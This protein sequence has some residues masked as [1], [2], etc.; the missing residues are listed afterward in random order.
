[1]KHGFYVRIKTIT[2]WQGRQTAQQAIDY[3]TDDHDSKRL[4]NINDEMI[5]YICRLDP[6]YKTEHEGGKVP[7]IGHGSVKHLTDFKELNWEFNQST[8]PADVRGT[9]GYK[10]ITLTLPKEMTLLCET[11]KRKAREAITRAIEP[12]LLESYPGQKVVAVSAMHTRNEAGDPH[13]NVHL[14]IGK[15]VLNEA[16]GKLYSINNNDIYGDLG[17]KEEAR[18]KRAWK[19]EITKELEIEFNVKI[20]ISKKGKCRIYTPDGLEL[21]SLK[22]PTSSEKKR[23]YE[24]AKGPEIDSWNGLADNFKINLMD[25][26]ILEVARKAP[27]TKENFLAV[28]PSFEKHYVIDKRIETLKQHRYLDEDL[29]PTEAFIR[30]AEAKFGHR[31]D[32]KQIKEDVDNIL[33]KLIEKTKDENP[34]VLEELVAKIFANPLQVAIETNEKIAERIERLDP[35]P[36][37]LQTIE[38]HW[39]DTRKQI[40]PEL[41]K[42]TETEHEHAQHLKDTREKSENLPP[43]TKKRYLEDRN[44]VATRLHQRAKKEKESAAA[45][46][47]NPI[48]KEH[49]TLLSTL[50]EDREL[51]QA[52]Q[53]KIE[54]LSERRDKE[55]DFAAE[56]E[57]PYI[58]KHYQ[59]Q[60]AEL[61]RTSAKL[62]SEITRKT[63]RA[64]GM[65]RKIPEKFKTYAKTENQPRNI[66]LPPE[67]A[68]KLHD[69][70]YRSKTSL[71]EY[72]SAR[73]PQ[74]SKECIWLRRGFKVMEIL[75]H[76]DV[77]MLKPIMMVGME[78]KLLQGYVQRNLPNYMALPT[79][80]AREMGKILFEAEHFFMFSR[81][82]LPKLLSGT[83]VE[84]RVNLMIA[85]LRVLGI[86][87]P[88]LSKINSSDF[89]AICDSD[90]RLWRLTSPG[91]AYMMDWQYQNNEKYE[92]ALKRFPSPQL[93]SPSPEKAQEMSYS[94][95]KDKD[96]DKD[97]DQKKEYIPPR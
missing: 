90:E 18:M 81:P 25:A 55:L 77:N 96:K 26:K 64:L 63:A 46:L 92:I 53:A 31:P 50:V 19:R 84:P 95:T 94:N 2:E 27:L 52:I 12:T 3:I 80:K 57:Y 74:L 39:V 49:N 17:S 44:L 28:F 16:T 68:Q 24:I 23:A 11:N 5:A 59:V 91:S 70:I 79:A 32:F 87:Y 83:S 42:W 69:Q 51:H 15:T 54:K 58:I 7:L 4:G 20:K 75:G 76:S 45:S 61:T 8:I 48:L 89:I 38:A 71:K 97:K 10:T 67:A 37:A 56:W 36:T 34:G 65:E 1:M 73:S 88:D 66:Y 47:K 85:R 62:R 33:G 41:A 29:K 60:I 6:G 21:P 22:L 40:T 13:V 86:Q 93:E 14:L 35:S 30:H 82:N 72:L 43:N 9:K 78:Q